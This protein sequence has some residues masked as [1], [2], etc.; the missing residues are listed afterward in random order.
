MTEHGPRCGAGGSPAL[1]Q[2]PAPLHRVE[3]CGGR[4]QRESCTPGEL[5]A[6]GAPRSTRS[7]FSH[8]PPS[9]FTYTHSGNKGKCFKRK[10]L[11]SF[12]FSLTQ[13]GL[14]WRRERKRKTAK[15]TRGFGPLQE[16]P[17]LCSKGRSGPSTGAGASGTGRC[18]RPAS[19]SRVPA[20]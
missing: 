3:G 16:A 7:G 9:S 19:V 11:G 4:R 6:R 5:H 15:R 1:R 8:V 17:R 18:T 14:I 13:K 10:V 20:P 12:F 2:L